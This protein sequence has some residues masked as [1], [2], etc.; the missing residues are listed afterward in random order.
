MT[1]SKKYT[2][3]TF[4]PT[5]RPSWAGI[6]SYIDA[7][8]KAEI[9]DAIICFPNESLGG[10]KSRFYNETIKPDLTQQYEKFVS[11]CEQRGRG[12][13]TYW[14]EHKLSISNTSDE[15]KD[16]LLKDKDKSQDKDKVKDKKPTLQEVI[17]YCNERNNGVDANKWFDYYTANGWKV[18][19]V[20]MKDWKATVRT[21]ERKQGKPAKAT[22]EGGEKMVLIDTNSFYLDDTMDEYK[23]LF[24][25]VLNKDDLALTVWKWIVK[26]FE[27]R[28]LKLSFIRSMIEKFKNEGGENERST[29]K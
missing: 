21:W 16:T 26:N 24:E 29:E 12:A 9:L 28:S 18:G 1:M 14:G 5:I 3:A 6:L 13:K 19:R 11:T 10:V 23:D 2:P 7:N 8:E 4:Q 27:G 25:G 20:P 17:D 22:N 15:H